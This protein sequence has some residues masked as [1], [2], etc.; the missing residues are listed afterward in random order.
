MKGKLFKGIAAVGLCAAMALGG[1]GC[2]WTQGD[3]DPD[4]DLGQN[5][6]SDRSGWEIGRAH[7]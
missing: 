4:V 3:Y 2:N 6:T 1:A 5:D 7:V